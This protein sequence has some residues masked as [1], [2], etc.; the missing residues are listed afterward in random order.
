VK[1]NDKSPKIKVSKK[2]G[3]HTYSS[4]IKA[5]IMLKK[6]KKFFENMVSL[7]LSRYVIPKFHSYI[8]PQGTKKYAK[9]NHCA[10]PFIRKYRTRIKCPLEKKS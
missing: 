10:I 5:N 3:F 4:R 9:K 7:G 6:N 8:N 1:I 2:I